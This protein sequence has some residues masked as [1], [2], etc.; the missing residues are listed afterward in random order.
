M[1]KT[2]IFQLFDHIS[3]LNKTHVL[4]TLAKHEEIQREEK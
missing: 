2:H 4:S 3:L 1:N